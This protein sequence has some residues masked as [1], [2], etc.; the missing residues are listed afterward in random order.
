VHLALRWAG[1]ETD[2]DLHYLRE[3]TW[4]SADDCYWGNRV[5]EWGARLERDDT[6]G[7]GPEFLDHVSPAP[8]RYLVQVQYYSVEDGPDTATVAVFVDGVEVLA[9]QREMSAM[10]AY[11]AVAQVDVAA[12]G[13]IAVAAVDLA[14]GQ[15]FDN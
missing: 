2:F 10:S 11:W 6:D 13:S 1:A 4:A 8:G 7:L 12:D 5:P 9:L 3:G 14:D 15:P